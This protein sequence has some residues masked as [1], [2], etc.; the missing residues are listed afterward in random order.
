MGHEPVQINAAGS[1]V[2]KLIAMLVTGVAAP[3]IEKFA[4]AEL[5]FLAF[6]VVKQIFEY[7]LEEYAGKLSFALQDGA[8]VIVFDV[9]TGTELH[10]VISSLTELQAAH[11][12]GDKDAIKKATDK[13][14][15]SWGD[16]IHWDGIASKH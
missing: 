9:Q 12:L 7:I 13:A 6:P 16:L 5:P 11:K 14:M 1:F 15:D 2:N 8:I 4:E 3:A 10:G